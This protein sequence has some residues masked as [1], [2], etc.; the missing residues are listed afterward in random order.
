MQ[1][2]F[3][4]IA[5]RS[6]QADIEIGLVIHDLLM[7]LGIE[8]F[9]IRLNNRK[10]LGGLLEKLQ[11]AEKATPVLRALDKLGKI[12]AEAVAREMAETAGTSEEQSSAV[13]KLAEM[14]GDHEEI[15]GQLRALLEGSPSGVE[16]L[17][18]LEAVLVGMQ[19]GGVPRERIALD[20]SI[21]RGL[22]YYTGT[23]YE[24]FLDDLPGIGSICSGGRYDNLAGLYTKQELPGVGASLGLDRLTAALEELDLL[25][26]I[27]TPAPVLIPLFDKQLANNYLAMAAAI[28]RAGIG[29]EVYPEAK[30]LGQQLK[31][32]DRRGFRFALIQGSREAE[33]HECQVKDLAGG[34]SETVST[35]PSFEP[36]IEYLRAKLV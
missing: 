1:C 19:A 6:V 24:T 5:T 17:A 23:I 36:L 11:L 9:K 2:D 33:T 21:A 18:E 30:K 14:T 29:V 4:I 3:D 25:E 10:I 16:G 31:Y 34:E 13:L 26:K 20:V 35:E 27:Q 15:F 22:D 32:A 28:R 7:A 12:G 8:R